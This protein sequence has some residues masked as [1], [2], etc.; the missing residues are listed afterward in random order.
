MML[1]GKRVLVTGG[2]SGIGASV[3]QI[4]AEAGARIA[5]LDLDEATASA[6]A[7]Q[8]CG[9]GH[10]GYACD[11]SIAASVDAG[12]AAVEQA[13]GG[14]RRRGQLRRHLASFVGRADHPRHG[15]DLGQDHSGQSD[16]HLLCLPCGRRG[17]GEEWAAA[18]SLRSPQSSL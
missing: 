11:V 8:L 16:R 9:A 1:E 2:A 10:L 13:F 7:R 4:C 12:F 18:A 5:V 15:R 3:A 17:H 14:H 6:A